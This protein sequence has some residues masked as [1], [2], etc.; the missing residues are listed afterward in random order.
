MSP[1]EILGYAASATVLAT[2]CMRTMIPLRIAALGS[3]FLFIG[4]GYLDHLTPVLLLHCI[5]LPV[6]AIRL[7]QFQ[8]LV[9]AMRKAHS[10]ELPIKNLLPYMSR[11]AMSAGAVLV[12]KGEQADRLYYLAEGELEIPNLRVVLKA[13]AVVGEIGIFAASQ[14]RSATVVC[15]TDCKLLQLT[16]RKARELYFQDRAFSFAVLQLIIQ[17]LSENNERLLQSQVQ[18]TAEPV[19]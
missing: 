12:R 8:Q 17:R 11:H 9:R 16:E 2:F 3:N 6:N 4:Y 19:G 10:G 7:V 14:A 18:G 1:V 15:R 5:L 13:G